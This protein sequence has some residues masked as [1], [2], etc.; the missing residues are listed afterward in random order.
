VAETVAV[1]TRF[2]YNPR[3]LR[4]RD[5]A[6]G[7]FVRGSTVKRA[8]FAVVKG[9]RAEM[10]RLTNDMIARRMDLGEWQDRFA[11]EV[12]NLHTSLAMAGAGG[13][14]SMTPSD[15][16]RV[17]QRLRFEYSRLAEFAVQLAERQFTPGQVRARVDMYCNAG[18]VS[19]EASRRAGAETAGMTEERNVLGPNEN[20]CHTN[21]KRPQ[22]EGCE[23]VSL[24]GWVKLGTLPA[25]GSRVCISNCKC[26]L[27]FRRTKPRVPQ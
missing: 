21:P 26:T 24:L 18:N 15:W 25:V 23:N 20:H 8:T 4:Y 14:A 13:M 10:R 12:K 16:G 22:R 17:G 11:A 2:T 6:S 9:S 7:R 1:K 27:A 3:T 5:N 19:F